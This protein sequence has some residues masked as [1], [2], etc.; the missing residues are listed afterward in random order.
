MKTQYDPEDDRGNRSA[1]S[2]NIEY[3]LKLTD[4]TPE[5]ME[6]LTTQ[7]KFRLGEGVGKTRPPEVEPKYRVN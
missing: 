1:Y 6:Q 4:I 3:K 7:M 5:R 2:G